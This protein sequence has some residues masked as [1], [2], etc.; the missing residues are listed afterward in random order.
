[1]HVLKRAQTVLLCMFILPVWGV[2]VIGCVT[3]LSSGELMEAP[4]PHTGAEFEYLDPKCHIFCHAWTDKISDSRTQTMP[5]ITKLIIL[6]QVHSIC[7]IPMV[8]C[9]FTWV[10]ISLYVLFFNTWLWNIWF[11]LKEKMMYNNNN[12]NFVMHWDSSLLL[13]LLLLLNH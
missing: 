1:M 13:L 12:N 3:G 2:C 9:I 4:L 8:M 11:Q 5:Q 6:F 7:M 10:I